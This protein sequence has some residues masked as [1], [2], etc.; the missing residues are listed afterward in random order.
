MDLK[1]G[2]RPLKAMIVKYR[3]AALRDHGWLGLCQEFLRCKPEQARSQE[4]V[5]P[6]EGAKVCG[7]T[8]FDRGRDH[9]ILACF[10]A[11][12][13][14]LCQATLTRMRQVYQ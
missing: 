11:E 12:K 6:V 14:D 2:G 8:R 1:T 4:V 9:L 10:E 7:A 5:L 13:P 3:S